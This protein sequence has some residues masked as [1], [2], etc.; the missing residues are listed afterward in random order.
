MVAQIYIPLPNVQGLIDLGFTKIEVW[1]ANGAENLYQEVTSS[2][3]GPASLSS[4]KASTTYRMGGR[5][6]KLS[7]D[8]GP[9]STVVFGSVLEYWTPSQVASRIN[10]VV[11]GLASS[12]DESVTLSSPTVGRASTISISYSDSP[13]LGFSA[14]MSSR[15][16]DQR[17]SL[18]G[19]TLAYLY[20]DVAGVEGGHYKW[21]VSR[22]GTE[23]SSELSSPISGSLPPVD[24]SMVSLATA[25]FLGVDGRARK[26]K[27]I[28][29]TNYSPATLG[30]YVV[31]SDPPMVFESDQFGML[32]VP[33]V[34]G[35]TVRVAIEGTPLVREFV[36]PDTGTF[37]LL[38]AM[39]TALDLFTIQTTTPYLVRRSL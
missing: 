6:L 17:I 33:M 34:K 1:V 9:E 14:G 23:P 4:S 21:R 11:P 10:E 37:D 30:G 38:G 12:H 32:V 25:R 24:P 35:M 5:L 13:N 7:V 36:V 29:A 2:S 18:S 28:V 39:G 22:D 8:G 31:G 19:S 15:G 16:R 27:V 26:T 3:P 20:S